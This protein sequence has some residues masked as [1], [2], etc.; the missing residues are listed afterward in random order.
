MFYS[1]IAQFGGEVRIE[2]PD[3][4]VRGMKSFLE[5]NLNAYKESAQRGRA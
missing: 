1:W 5:A 4:A 3:E 2:G